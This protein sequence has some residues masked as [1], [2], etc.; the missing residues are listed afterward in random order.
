MLPVFN[1][2][3]TRPAFRSFWDDDFFFTPSVRTNEP[4]VNVSSD[5]K[6]YIVELAAP[7]MDKKDLKIEVEENL[8]TISS[9]HKEE[10]NEKQADYSRREFNYSSF[11]K[12]FSL[13]EDVNA[14]KIQANYNNGILAIEIPRKEEKAKV[15]KMI[16]I[17]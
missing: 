4:A 11:S 10:K 16:D 14:E 5:E 6:K 17:K 12:C 15:S 7:G 8:L 13:P 9:E 1:K 3:T 2:P